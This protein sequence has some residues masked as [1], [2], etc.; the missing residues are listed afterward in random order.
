MADLCEM[1][2]EDVGRFAEWSQQ[3]RLRVNGLFALLALLL[4]IA[5]NTEP[6][7]LQDVR[8]IVGG[9]VEFGVVLTTPG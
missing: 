2:W 1:Q 9:N 5:D 3:R 4:Q 7:G 6:P 8:C